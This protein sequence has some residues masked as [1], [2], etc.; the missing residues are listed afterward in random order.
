MDAQKAAEP[1]DEVIAPTRSRRDLGPKAPTPRAFRWAVLWVLPYLILGIS[2]AIANPPSAAADEHNNLI[3]ILAAGRFDIGEKYEGPPGEEVTEIRNNSISR[4]VSVPAELEVSDDFFCTAFR[5]DQTAD[6]LP[7]EGNNATGVVEQKTAMGA[8]PVFF[9]VPLGWAT[10]LADNTTRAF[11]LARLAE[12][13]MCMTVM[14]LAVW[15]LTRWL[16]RGAAIGLAVGLTPMAVFH[17][18]TASTVGLEIVG[19]AAV[20]AVLITT[21]RWPESL[22]NRGSLAVLTVGGTAL[23]LS[24]QIGALTFALLAVIALFSGAGPVL[25]RQLRQGR[26]ALI[27]AAAILAIDTVAIIVW[28]QLYDHPALTGT[29]FDQ[30]A[31]GSF[32]DGSF[33][34]LRTGI[35]YFGWNDTVLPGPFMGLW[36]LLLMVTVGAGMLVARRSDLWRMIVVLLA[37]GVSAYA[38]AAIVF[39]PIGGGLQGRHMIPMFI[40]VPMLAGVVLRERWGAGDGRTMRRFGWFIGVSVALVQMV[41]FYINGQRYAVGWNGPVWWLDEAKWEPRFGWWPWL[42]TFAVGCLLLAFN[43][44]RDARVQ[45]NPLL[46]ETV[47]TGPDDPAIGAQLSGSDDA[48]DSDSDKSVSTR[49][50]DGSDERAPGSIR[51]PATSVL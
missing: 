25:W 24:R 4:I 6:C 51:R 10:L 17:L 29:V 3:K 16:G 35:G 19:A 40:V 7:K 45:P 32:I 50:K 23:I 9:F 37:V 13:A 5:P 39:F 15:Q 2:W 12:V 38:I 22:A 18:S 34:Y 21:T 43:I 1:V 27:V 31:W 36:I 42:I 8:Y 14:L 11:H 30:Q 41:A 46:G 48:D 44:I 49:E 20:A 33:V 47:T 28:E 26:P